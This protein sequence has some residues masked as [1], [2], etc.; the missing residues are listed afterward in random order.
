MPSSSRQPLARSAYAALAPFGNGLTGMAVVIG[1]AALSALILSGETIRWVD[2]RETL[3]AAPMLRATHVLAGYVLV[4]ALLLRVG[5]AVLRGLEHW[6]GQGVRRAVPALQ[7]QAR[8]AP[9]ALLDAAWWLVVFALA[10]SGLERYTQLRY[11]TS[12]LPGLPPA[13]WWALHRPLVPYLY[14][15]LLIN[16]VIRGRM[17]I[18]RA[19]S[20]LY[21]P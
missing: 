7:W 19:L 9:T 10:L 18:R 5:A 8:L 6:W 16:V 14:A 3:I 4:A 20:Y 13:A 12:V 2:Y 21:T 1:H 17:S 11:G 15:V